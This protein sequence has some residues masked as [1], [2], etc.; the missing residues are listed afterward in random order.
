M[1]S[2][3]RRGSSVVWPRLSCR[4]LRHGLHCPAPLGQLEWN[5]NDPVHG[6]RL[7]F[8]T[9][10]LVLPFLDRGHGCTGERFLAPH[11]LHVADLTVGQNDHFEN[12]HPRLSSGARFLRIWWRDVAL[13]RHWRCGVFRQRNGTDL[14]AYHT[15]LAPALEASR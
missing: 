13:R 15:A 14:T 11:H 7:A 3:Q 4:T 1:V 8:V 10:R 6:D 12:D 2:V 9:R 5:L